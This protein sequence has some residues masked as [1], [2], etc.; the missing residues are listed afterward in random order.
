[1]RRSLA[2][3]ALVLACGAPPRAAEP[4][5]PV[6]APRPA[7]DGTPPDTAPP[8]DGTPLPAPRTDGRTAS[9]GP[10]IR[11][12]L[13]VGKNE[14]VIEGSQGV[15]ASD[16]S[17]S[18]VARVGPGESMVA[19]GEGGTVSL[20]DRRGRRIAREDRLGFHSPGGTLL[21][22]GRAYRGRAD[23]LRDARG[24]TLVNA[25]ALEEYL[26]SVV[27]AE[28]GTRRP[29]EIEAVMAQAIVARTYALRNLG[30]ARER[31]YDL[32]SGVADQVYRGAAGEDSLAVR[33]VE[34][35]R[36]IIVTWQ[37]SPIDA[38]F[39]S[40]CAGESERG[41][42]VFRGADRPYL[43]SAP[44]VDAN[45]EAWCRISPRY[46]WRE[47]WTGRELAAALDASL[48]ELGVRVPA[49]RGA[50]RN[51]A[52][53]GRTGTGRANLLAIRWEHADVSVRGQEVRRA[54]RPPAG[55]WLRSAQFTL[56]PEVREGKLVRL[57]AEGAGAGH[58]VGMCQWGAIGRARAGFQYDAIL[59]AYY[60]GTELVRFY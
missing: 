3:A 52:V 43:R 40:T 9:L 16:P 41:V 1:M 45:G 54:L 12:G 13:G 2:A 23:V 31:G 10:D 44:D 19:K 30:R 4:T 57:V 22:D 59:A 39:S 14:I 6:P 29:D 20:F 35:T 42:D 5:A 49:G 58:G 36:G 26:P 50:V 56:E 32:E 33:A 55:G 17:G 60:P 27:A 15:V 7:P 46:R 24:V 25:V 21:L 38:F 28:L 47:E 11:V 53:T 34:A 8:P 51:V 37:G 18:T 48:G